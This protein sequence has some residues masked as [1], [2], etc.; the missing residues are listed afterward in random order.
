MRSRNGWPFPRYP[1]TLGTAA[2]SAG[3]RNGSPGTSARP[4]FPVAEV[5]ETG[6]D[7]SGLPAVFAHWPAADPSA[8]VV[9]VYGHHD[10][11][12]VE[13]LDEWDSPPFEPVQR[14]GQLVARGASDDKGHVLFHALAVRA[15]LASGDRD[16]PP[17]TLKLLIEGEEESGSTNFAALLEARRDR[18]A[19]DVIVVSDTTM[20][21]ADVPSMC[22]GMRGCVDGRHRFARARA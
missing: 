14:D 11:Q 18:L 19:C 7:G 15:S 20:W 16:A 12:P 6:E 21:A 1:P 17:V 13:P 5:W 9:L 2:T 10:V 3:R 4:A 22:T 8:P